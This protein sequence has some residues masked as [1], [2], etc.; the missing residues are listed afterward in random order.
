VPSYAKYAEKQR[1][2]TMKLSDEPDGIVHLK[3][4][5]ARITP[6][7]I[8]SFNR[9]ASESTDA[10]AAMVG[11]SQQVVDTVA[12]WDLTEDE[13]PDSPLVPL[14]VERLAQLGLFFIIELLTACLGGVRDP[15]QPAATQPEPSPLR[16]VPGRKGSM[17]G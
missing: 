3:F 7:W 5:P 14:T 6:A 9:M 10:M 16:S 13:A 4:W 15:E 1:D 2:A 17:A 8:D 11:L 12:W